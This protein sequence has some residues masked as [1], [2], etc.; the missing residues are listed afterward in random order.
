MTDKIETEVVLSPNLP[1]EPHFDASDFR[2]WMAMSKEYLLRIGCSPRQNYKKAYWILRKQGYLADDCLK[3]AKWID[4][5][6]EEWPH[7]IISIFSKKMFTE[8]VPKWFLNYLRKLPQ[9]IS[10][11][12][13]FCRYDEL[14][15]IL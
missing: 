4:S 10:P 1:G 13:R 3:L 2:G 15:E 11:V 7:E 6:E 12:I 5:Y 9:Q 14:E 8:S